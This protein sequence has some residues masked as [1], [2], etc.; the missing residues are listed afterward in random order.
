MFELALTYSDM[1]D[2]KSDQLKYGDVNPKVLSKINLLCNKAINKFQEFIDTYKDKQSGE[3]PENLDVDELQVVACSYF[4][5]G[6][7]YYKIITPD[8]KMQLD[9]TSKSYNHYKLFIG[10]CE[11][12]KPIAEKMQGELGVTK[13]MN[14]LLPLKIKKLMEEINGGS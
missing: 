2:I 3:V 10:Y 12:H 9:N 8:K 7:L 11:R 6:R 5:L 13:S 1:L 14:E 4:N